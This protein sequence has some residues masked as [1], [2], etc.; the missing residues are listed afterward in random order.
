MAPWM[1][2]FYE[3][4][5]GQA[6]RKSIGKICLNIVQLETILTEIEAVINSR[7]LV[8]VGADL[9]SG[10]ALTPGAFLSL[11]PKTGVPFLETEDE[12]LQDP[13]SVEKLS[14]AKKL[15][16]T[17]KKGHNILTHSGNC[18]LMNMC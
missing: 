3:R 15:L 16:E 4:L 17:W 8:Y 11:N 12:Q 18:G 1:G 10:F 2:G 5:V 6:L 14:S 13:D 9:K 7:P